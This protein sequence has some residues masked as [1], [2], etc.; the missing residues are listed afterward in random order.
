MC[1][2]ALDFTKQKF[3]DQS[4][5]TAKLLDEKTSWLNNGPLMLLLGAVAGIAVGSIVVGV[6]R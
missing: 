3:A 6:A 2:L 4:Q 5:M 1:D